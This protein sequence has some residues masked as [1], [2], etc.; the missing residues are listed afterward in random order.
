MLY[1]SAD[2]LKPEYLY[3]LNRRFI[4]NFNL[5]FEDEVSYL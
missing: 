4:N 5:S 2:C 3:V 1:L